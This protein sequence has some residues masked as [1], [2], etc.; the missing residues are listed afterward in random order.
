MIREAKLKDYGKILELSKTDNNKLL[1]ITRHPLAQ[2]FLRVLGRKTF[3]L[4]Q[5]GRVVGYVMQQKNKAGELFVVPSERKKGYGT[6]L[7]LFIEDYILQRYPRMIIDCKKSSA[8]YYSNK[9]YVFDKVLNS[10][11]G[12]IRLIKNANRN[13]L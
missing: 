13:L 8:E 11:Q 2:L 6:Q 3:L 5:E 7:R 4:E 10:L 12:G 9:G 1:Q